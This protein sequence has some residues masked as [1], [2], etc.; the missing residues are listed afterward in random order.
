MASLA[1]P[2]NHNV[3]C[4]ASSL[5]NIEAWDEFLD[6]RIYDCVRGVVL[7]LLRIVA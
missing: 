7:V 5:A 6:H 4:V 1:S 2:G 3:V